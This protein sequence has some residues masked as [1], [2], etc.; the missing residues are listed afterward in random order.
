MPED[1]PPEYS[2]AQM[3]ME[4]QRV[5]KSLVDVYAGKERT[6]VVTVALHILIAQAG[7][8]QGNSLEEV[9]QTLAENVPLFYKKILE[10]KTEQ[11]RPKIVL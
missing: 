9:M 10:A 7:V 5:A 1:Q 3:I 8:H 2:Q 4:A 11:S 6:G